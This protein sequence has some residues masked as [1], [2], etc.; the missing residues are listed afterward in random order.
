MLAGADRATAASD[1]ECAI[2][3]CLPGGFPPGCGAAA[4]AM[5]KRLHR[6]KP[7]LPSWNSCAAAD[8]G[9]PGMEVEYGRDPFKECRKGYHLATSQQDRG[10]VLGQCVSDE[11]RNLGWNEWKPLHT[12]RAERRPNGGRY[13]TITTDDGTPITE[14]TREGVTNDDPRIFY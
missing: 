14:V 8:P 7:P 10:P 5:A 9:E 4:A 3:I 11:K 2:W 12:Y 13:L 1:D 6:F